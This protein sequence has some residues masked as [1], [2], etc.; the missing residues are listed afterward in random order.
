V[1]GGL[2]VVT[3]LILARV[4]A[5]TRPVGLWERLFLGAA[6]LWMLLVAVS[7]A[8]PASSPGGSVSSP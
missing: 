7:L 6:L 8:M 5:T 3:F 2:T 4:D 1:L